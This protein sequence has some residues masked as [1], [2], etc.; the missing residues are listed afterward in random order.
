M[1]IKLF[2]VYCGEGGGREVWMSSLS[3][4]VACPV[5]DDGVWKSAQGHSS[6]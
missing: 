3:A 2:G 1:M 5:D 6:K 4:L